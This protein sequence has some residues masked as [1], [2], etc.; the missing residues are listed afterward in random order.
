MYI[1]Q[2]LQMKE[3]ET[4]NKFRNSKAANGSRGEKIHKFHRFK[5]SHFISHY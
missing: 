2:D 5:K 3:D 4:E 1:N